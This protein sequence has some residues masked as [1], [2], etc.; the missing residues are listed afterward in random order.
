[1]KEVFPQTPFQELS[2][3]V[4]HHDFLKVLGILKPFFQE[5]FKPPEA[6][7]PLPYKPKFEIIKTPIKSIKKEVISA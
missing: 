2:K 6:V 4:I 7:P 1:M 3:R 5:G